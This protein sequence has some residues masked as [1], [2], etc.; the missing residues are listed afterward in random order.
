[1]LVDAVTEERRS[2]RET[3]HTDRIK[4]PGRAGGVGAINGTVHARVL[5]RR[6]GAGIDEHPVCDPGEIEGFRGG[7]HHRRAGADG[8]ESVGGELHDHGIG[9][10]LDKWGGGAHLCGRMK[11]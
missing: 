1:M 9:Q 8:Q 2:F 11:I 7:V 3:T 6:W 10:A 5:F 4:H